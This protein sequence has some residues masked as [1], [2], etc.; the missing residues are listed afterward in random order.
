MGKQRLQRGN[1]SLCELIVELRQDARDFVFD[2]GELSLLATHQGQIGDSWPWNR[3]AVRNK[4]L[5]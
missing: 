3:V 1:A 2:H 4:P 5:E